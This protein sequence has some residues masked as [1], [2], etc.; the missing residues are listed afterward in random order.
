MTLEI[1][2]HFNPLK[3]YLFINEITANQFADQINYSAS[4]LSAYILGK[5]K[6]GRYIAKLIELHTKGE[7]TAEELLKF[8]SSK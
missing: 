3:V 4:A 8:E 2:K 5:R 1:P 6:I 7:L